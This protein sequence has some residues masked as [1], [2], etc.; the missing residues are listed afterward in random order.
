MSQ[1]ANTQRIADLSIIDN[2][3][4]EIADMRTMDRLNLV[5]YSGSTSILSQGIS[6]KK[7][8]EGVP[9]E[10]FQAE[11]YTSLAIEA[12]H[13]KVKEMEAEDDFYHTWELGTFVLGIISHLQKKQFTENNGRASTLHKIASLPA[14][15][16]I[17]IEGIERR[18]TRAEAMMLIESA[19][20]TESLD[21]NIR[22]GSGNKSIITYTPSAES[23]A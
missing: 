22:D 15:A 4:C 20:Q 7:V 23:N 1:I 12:T 11:K 3:S 5:G 8:L 21:L 14:H 9:L 17:S 13:Y 6:L 18:L 10:N 19:N 2:W 16:R